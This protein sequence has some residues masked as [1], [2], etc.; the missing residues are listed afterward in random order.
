[1]PDFPGGPK[2]EVGAAGKVRSES[3]GAGSA[4]SARHHRR[5]EGAGRRWGVGQRPL[6]GPPAGRS[7]RRRRRTAEVRMDSQAELPGRPG[8]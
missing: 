6:D 8:A 5:R 1:M 3:R 7:G 2:G 4:R